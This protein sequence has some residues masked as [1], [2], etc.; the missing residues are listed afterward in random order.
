MTDERVVSGVHQFAGRALDVGQAWVSDD[1]VHRLLMCICSSPNVVGGGHPADL[2][3]ASPGKVS[4]GC[5]VSEARGLRQA[6]VLPRGVMSAL[7]RA[8]PGRSS[9]DGVSSPIP[10]STLL[11]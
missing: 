3:R 11:D 2:A 4:L 9:S 7:G 5:V 1:E 10:S 6:D 8:L